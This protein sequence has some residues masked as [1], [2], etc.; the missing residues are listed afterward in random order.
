MTL[1]ACS[2]RV[3]VDAMYQALGVD[4]HQSFEIRIAQLCDGL[5][6]RYAGT[7]DDQ[8]DAMVHSCGLGKGEHGGAVGDIELL[9]TLSGQSFCEGVTNA[10]V[11]AND[12]G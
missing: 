11:R 8:L 1:A 9:V 3:R 10:R 2:G 6:G 4:S 5:R 12:D 7:I